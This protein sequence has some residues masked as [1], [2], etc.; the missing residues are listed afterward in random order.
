MM[1]SFDVIALRMYGHGSH[2]A[3]AISDSDEG[4]ES[5]GFVPL[6]PGR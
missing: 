2:L 1:L 5:K 4:L 3:L 6:L